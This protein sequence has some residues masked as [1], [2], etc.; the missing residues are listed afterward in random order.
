[1]VTGPGGF[2]LTL[3]L[4]PTGWFGIYQGKKLRAN[5]DRVESLL[6][7][8]SAVHID[9]FIIGEGFV[10]KNWRFCFVLAPDSVC[11]EI[12]ER[13]TDMVQF[14]ISG[15]TTWYFLTRNVDIERLCSPQNM[16]IVFQSK[17][18]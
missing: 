10:S 11:V 1:M 16:E 6:K 9:S 7:M 12:G 13:F 5:D 4:E 14:R 15:D 3:E 2:A 17:S 18:K 8:F